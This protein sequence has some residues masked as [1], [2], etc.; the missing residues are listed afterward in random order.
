MADGYEVHADEH[1]VD[2]WASQLLP[3]QT[4]GSMRGYRTDLRAGLARLRA[5]CPALYCSYSSPDSA[6]CDVENVLFYNVGLSAFTHLDVAEVVAERF[7][8]P[9]PA[10]RASH[11]HH[12]RCGEVPPSAE[13]AWRTTPYHV[14]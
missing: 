6:R 9:P 4:K 13:S 14:G 2:G 3:Y 1:A 5:P 12:Y 8:G 11:H 7:T 10:G